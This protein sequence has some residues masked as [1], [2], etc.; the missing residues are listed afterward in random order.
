MAPN[1]V[2]RVTEIVSA[3]G[4]GARCLFGDQTLFCRASDFQRVG[5][6]DGSLPIMEDADLGIRMH[7]AG[8]QPPLPAVQVISKVYNEALYYPLEWPCIAYVYF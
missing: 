6:F 5:G 2:Y 8:P 1:H 4:R 7:E 3:V